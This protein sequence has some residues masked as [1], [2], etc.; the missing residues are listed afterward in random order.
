MQQILAEA[1]RR[2]LRVAG[3]R[4]DAPVVRLRLRQLI[5]DQEYDTSLASV[6]RDLSA[7]AAGDLAEPG[8]D[9]SALLALL[10]SPELADSLA[11]GALFMCGDGGWPAG[12]WPADPETYW[13][14]SVRS[15]AT[16]PVF[17]PLVNGMIAPCAFWP[18]APREPGTGIGPTPC[19]C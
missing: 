18:T 7:A 3:T 17:G 10:S 13:R 11:G 4:L 15:R 1:E 9:L 6:V 14:N 12:G 8:P 2:P 5:Q 16:E 19:P